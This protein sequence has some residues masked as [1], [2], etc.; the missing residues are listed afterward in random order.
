M[1]DSGQLTNEYEISQ[2]HGDFEKDKKMHV[3]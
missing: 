1:E 3:V 2:M